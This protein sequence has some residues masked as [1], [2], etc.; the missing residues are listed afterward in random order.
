M[1]DGRYRLVDPVRTTTPQ[2]HKSIN[3]LEGASKQVG[4][5]KVLIAASVALVAA[6]AAA[7]IYTSQFVSVSQL[8]EA[9]EGCE[10]A[11]TTHSNSDGHPSVSQGIKGIDQRLIRV[12]TIQQRMESAQSDMSQKIDRLIE[13]VWRVQQRM[14]TPP[15]QP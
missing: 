12:E 9:Q 7:A 5:L 14:S 3:P 11:L 8:K 1:T 4:W 10:R 15:Y 13:S 2:P 6:G